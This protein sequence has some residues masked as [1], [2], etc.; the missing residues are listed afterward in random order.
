MREIELFGFGDLGSGSAVLLDTV[1][2][3]FSNFN[4][5][6]SGGQVEG[7]RERDTM[8]MG[9]VRELPSCALDFSVISSHNKRRIVISCH[10]IRSDSMGGQHIQSSSRM[11]R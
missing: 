2:S 9:R 1:N 3:K 7:E 6:D 11:K 10:V 8:R 5:Y 4:S